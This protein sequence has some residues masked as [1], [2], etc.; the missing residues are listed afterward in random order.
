M[1]ADK[2]K[3]IGRPPLDPADKSDKRPFS[4][5]LSPAHIEELKR[6]GVAALEKWLDRKRA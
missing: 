5:R 4:V 6:R 3:R 1:T 2:P